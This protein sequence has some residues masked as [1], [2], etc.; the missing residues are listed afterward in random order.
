MRITLD[1]AHPIWER[2]FMVFPLV[3]VAT[4]EPDGSFD[5]APKHMAT[6]LSWDNHFGFV[7][8]PTHATYQNARREGC[9]TVSFPRPEQVVLT[10][11][12]AAPRCEDAHKHS[13]DA[14]LTV[15]ATVIDGVLLDTAYLQL[16]CELERIVDGFGMNSLV[17]GNV[18][19]AHVD[20]A[21]HREIDMDDP[22]LLLDAPLLAYLYP[23]RYAR[24]TESFSF[25][26]HD[27]FQR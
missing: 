4:K 21:A 22:E 17:A 10:S 11:L 23:G 19:A 8:T 15:P 26:F 27:G 25:P 12:A 18:V 24:I 5:L 9:F 20:E 16:E 14:L 13:L 2:F 1:P 3:L 6:P 7:C